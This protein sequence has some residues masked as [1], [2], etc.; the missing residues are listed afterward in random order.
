M[1]LLQ[2]MPGTDVGLMSL[3]V[4]AGVLVIATGIAVL[5]VRKVR[6]DELA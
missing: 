5:V 3:A 1:K 2:E 4:T 6:H